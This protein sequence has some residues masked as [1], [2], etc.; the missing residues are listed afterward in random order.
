MRAFIVLALLFS[1]AISAFAES[2]TAASDSQTPPALLVPPA[3]TNPQVQPPAWLPQKKPAVAPSITVPPQAQSETSATT[4]KDGKSIDIKP[5]KV[6]TNNKNDVKAK[7]AVKQGSSVRKNHDSAPK[8][9]KE[10]NGDEG[11]PIKIESVLTKDLEK[12]DQAQK[13]DNTL[14]M[15]IS[16]VEL[17][18]TLKQQIAATNKKLKQS[19]SETEK[20]NLQEEIVHLDKQLN[21]T[22]VD[23]ERL[24][25]GVDSNVFSDKQ[26]SSFSWKE[27][28]ATL[29]EPSVKELKQL[30][31]KARQKSELK[32]TIGIYEKQSA[33]AHNAVEHIQHLIAQSSDSKIKLYL[34]ELLPAWQNMTKRIDGKLDLAKRELAQLEASDVSIIQSAGH[35]IRVFFRDRG[36]FIL[37]A[38]GVF[39]GTLLGIRLIARLILRFLPGARRDNRPAHIRFL[40]VFFQFFS[41]FA[42]I[43]GLIA[44]LYLAEDWFLLSAA[45]VLM[46]GLVW[47]VRQTLPKMW[48]QARLMLNMGSIREGERII[49]QGVPW[50]VEAINVFCKLY[51]PAMAHRLRIPIENM[52]GLVSRPFEQDEPWFPCHKGD[53]VVIDGKPNAKVVSI[54]H[55]MVEVVELGGRKI[56]YP[57]ADFL[58]LSPANLS[59]NFFIRVVFGLSYDLQE[60]ITS[61]VLE[62]LNAFLQE[63]FDQNG[64]TE[65]CL[66]LSVDFLQAGASSLDVV[67]FA[68]MRGDQAPSIGKIER[69]IARWCVDCCNLNNWEIPFPQMTVHLPDQS[70]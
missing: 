11:E 8:N 64:F 43:S 38:L 58:S 7:I 37:I 59:T 68:N 70:K 69:S 53:W 51:N 57:T 41:V 52:I 13:T 50:K 46:L 28:L 4:E 36:W 62:K 42:A 25:T 67:I 22:G 49:Y 56:V 34:S 14:E 63:K 54:S 1:I 45:I 65:G 27:E 21:E 15:L 24:A 20:Q 5:I 48:Q 17:Q 32:D 3:A 66:S 44:A 26:D 40:T 19:R 29:I 6:K 31:A 30:T 12:Q 23:F 9:K 47:A 18:K 61:T 60:G 2:Q 16:L 10:R 35:T 55:E 39:F 33:T